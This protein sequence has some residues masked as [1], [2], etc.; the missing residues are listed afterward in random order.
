VFDNDLGNHDEEQASDQA[1]QS[2]G[3]GELFP[4]EMD[5]IGMDKKAVAQNECCEHHNKIPAFFH[6]R[7]SSFRTLL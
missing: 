1:D 7:T 2:A 3:K 5:I 4:D 6:E